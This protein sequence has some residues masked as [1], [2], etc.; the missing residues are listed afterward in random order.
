MKGTLLRALYF[1]QHSELEATRVKENFEHLS[2]PLVF[3]YARWRKHCTK[4]S[5]ELAQDRRAWGASV[6]DVVMPAQPALGECRY[7]YG[8]KHGQGP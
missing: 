5:C 6:H 1:L 7:K 8:F 2:G 3:G 4:E